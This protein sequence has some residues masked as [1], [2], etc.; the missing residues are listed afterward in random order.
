MERT[1]GNEILG[2]RVDEQ[3]RHLR[4]VVGDPDTLA[5]LIRE[6][7]GADTA[8]AARFIAKAEAIGEPDVPRGRSPQ[9]SFLREVARRDYR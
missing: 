7:T 4:N 5:R 9:K 8:F 6:E 2:L 3:Y 1:A